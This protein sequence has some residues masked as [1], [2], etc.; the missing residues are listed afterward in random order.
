MPIY[1]IRGGQPKLVNRIFRA[2]GTGL[3]SAPPEVLMVLVA[4]KVP[5]QTGVTLKVVHDRYQVP[6]TNLRITSATHLSCQLAWTP[7]PGA[8]PS[9]EYQVSYKGRPTTTSNAAWSGDTILPNPSEWTP[10]NT[11]PVTALQQN[12]EYQFKIRARRTMAD[13]TYAT[14]PYATT[15]PVLLTGHDARVFQ[16][17]SYGVDPTGYP[18]GK[19]DPMT[20]NAAG[21]GSW[22]PSY[23]WG[24]RFDVQQ[25]YASGTAATRNARGAVEYST[26]RTQLSNWIVSKHPGIS[27][28]ELAN[29]LNTVVL[30]DA[31]IAQIYRKTGGSGTPTIKVYPSKINR[32]VTTRPAGYG[33]TTDGT[34]F[35]SPAV[36]KVRL[37]TAISKLTAWATE[38]IK[39]AP[40]HNG[41]L[42]YN[43]TASGSSTA[44]YNGYAVFRAARASAP[45]TSVDADWQLKLLVKWKYTSPELPPT[46]H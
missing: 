23:N 43:G 15:V 38:W 32:S 46:W 24:S 30:S 21:T 29:V 10:Q 1:A 34:T 17:P 22:T 5:G 6:P 3:S 7:P 16:N 14:S 26:A 45:T 25:G 37:D 33:G 2:A 9:I 8:A 31:K 4:V 20:I 36:G 40:L 12:Y 42:I 44:G 35:V 18:A 11:M 39:P 41:M 27:A 13:G 28:G 19:P